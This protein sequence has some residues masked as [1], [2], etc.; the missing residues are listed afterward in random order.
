MKVMT[1][2]KTDNPTVRLLVISHR[3]VKIDDI[4]RFGVVL[5]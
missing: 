1:T 4:K 2:A 5:G 3:L